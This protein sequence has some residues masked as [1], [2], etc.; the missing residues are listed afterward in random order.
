MY[1]R[2]R[3]SRFNSLQV[4]ALPSHGTAS[5]IPYAPGFYDTV[6]DA[7]RKQLKQCSGHGG[8]KLLAALIKV[9][10]LFLHCREEDGYQSRLA[11]LLSEVRRRPE[12][13]IVVLLD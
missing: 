9:D 6:V 5:L 2:D 11:L 4:S 8:L 10:S 1:I 13:L 3:R 12:L 7:W